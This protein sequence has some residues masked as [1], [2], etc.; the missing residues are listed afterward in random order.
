MFEGFLRGYVRGRESWLSLIFILISSY[1][2]DK[3]K[4]ENFKDSMEFFYRI[5]FDS[6]ECILLLVY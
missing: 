3:D 6:V 5:F 1:L 2:I 4:R